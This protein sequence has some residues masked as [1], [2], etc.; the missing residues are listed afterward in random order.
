[1]CDVSGET[2]GH[3]ALLLFHTTLCHFNVVA[4]TL[5]INETYNENINKKCVRCVVSF[6]NR[7]FMLLSFTNV[8]SA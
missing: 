3:D 6:P 2:A 5:T 7:K 4:L 1:M 8:S